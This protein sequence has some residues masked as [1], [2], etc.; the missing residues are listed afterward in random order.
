MFKRNNRA[1]SAQNGMR[2]TCQL[3]KNDIRIMRQNNKRKINHN[4]SKENQ[5]CK[6]NRV[7]WK[8]VSKIINLSN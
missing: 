2:M 5:N 7:K 6:S 3:P 8:Q 1:E 4:N